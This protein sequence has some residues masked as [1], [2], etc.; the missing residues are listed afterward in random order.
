VPDVLQLEAAA[1]GAA[2]VDEQLAK[3]REATVAAQRRHQRR[4]PELTARATTSGTP[5]PFD[6]DAAAQRRAAW[7]QG[8]NFQPTA[9][10]DVDAGRGGCRDVNW[11]VEAV[12]SVEQKH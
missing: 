7:V 4:L 11:T 3:A 8:R 1:V 2:A 6:N 5:P 9:A 10:L 12:R